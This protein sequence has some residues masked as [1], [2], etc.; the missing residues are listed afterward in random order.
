[1]GLGNHGL[2]GCHCCEGDTSGG[3]NPCNWNCGDTTNYLLNWRDLTTRT[4]DPNEDGWYEDPRDRDVYEVDGRIWPKTYNAYRHVSD[5]EWI[6]RGG[7][8]DWTNQRTRIV[9]GTTRQRDLPIVSTRAP[10]GQAG[11][12]LIECAGIGYIGHGTGIAASCNLL[13]PLT[14]ES[15]FSYVIHDSNGRTIGSD[16]VRPCSTVV[17]FEMRMTLGDIVETGTTIGGF[18]YVRLPILREFTCTDGLYFR[19]EREETIFNVLQRQRILCDT[20]VAISMERALVGDHLWDWIWPELV[21][22][23]AMSY[24]AF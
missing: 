21:H 6:G 3:G 20:R 23:Q 15:Y 13:D 12:I 11:D 17:S 18:C 22:I 7:A 2:A 24:E 14:A 10:C 9:A 1:M 8:F 5:H 19:D 16:I 4:T